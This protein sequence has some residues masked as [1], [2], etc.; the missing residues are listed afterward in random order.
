MK[1]SGNGIKEIYHLYKIYMQ[2]GSPYAICSIETAISIIYVCR[3]SLPTIITFH[4]AFIPTQQ[5]PSTHL[6]TY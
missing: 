1:A 2:Y 5:Y 6:T 4:P 3:L